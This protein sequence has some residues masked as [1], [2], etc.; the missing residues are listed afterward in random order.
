MEPSIAT[1]TTEMHREECDVDLAVA[2]RDDPRAFGLLFQR[3]RGAVYRFVRARTTSDDEAAELTAVTFERAF[4]AMPRY[5]PVDGAG[6]L[7]WLLRIARNAA[8]DASRRRRAATPLDD[9]PLDDHPSDPSDPESRVLEAEALERIRDLVRSL[10][11]P[12]RDAVILRYATRLPARE[13][14][15]VIGKSQAA[16]EKL[17]RR[18]LITLKEAWDVEG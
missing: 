8:V 6:P 9:L 1:A 5:R 4:V 15:T 10:P 11:G 12:Q 14:A 16:T 2:A 17:L 13:I 3:H 18:A 7:S